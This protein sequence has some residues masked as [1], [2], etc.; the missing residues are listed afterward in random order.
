MGVVPMV[1]IL[2]FLRNISLKYKMFT[3]VV[4]NVITIT[5]SAFAA[6]C[7]CTRSYNDLIFQALAG[8]LS[9]SAC[10]IAEKLKNIEDL[11]STILS[12]PLIQQHLS[13]LAESEDTLYASEARRQL[14]AALFSLSTPYDSIG[15][16]YIALYNPQFTS[17]TNWNLLNSI[18]QDLLSIALSQAAEQEGAVTWIP[19]RQK[20]NLI[21]GRSIRKVENLDLTPIGNLLI[22]VDLE[23]LVASIH[24]TSSLW[25]DTAYILTDHKNRRIYASSQFRFQDLGP[26]LPEADTPYQLVSLGGHTYFLVSGTLPGY[27]YR[28][29]NLFPYDSIDS[30][31]QMTLGATLVIMI[32]GIV[33]I[34]IVS[35]KLIQLVARQLDDLIFKMQA[36]SQD[37]LTL[38]AG[39]YDYLKQNDEIGQ[40]HQQF[41][42][43]A[44]R[45][46]TLVKTNY[47]N[48]LLTTEMKLKTL[49][50]QINPHFL[51]N[52]LES[53]NWRAKAMQN[54]EISQMAESLGMILRMTL[55]T[56]KSLVTLAYELNLVRA[57]MT[58]QKIR[59][60]ERLLYEV[61][62]GESIGDALIPPLTIQPLVE[63]AI[64]YGL[65]EMIENCHIII[66]AIL[67]NMRLIIRVK[68]EGSCFEPNL[69]ETLKS[70]QNTPNG[71][72]IGLMNVQ[73]R[74]RIL[75]GEEYG[76]SF[77]NEGSYAVATLTLPYQKEDK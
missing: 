57:Y 14:N 27:D 2:F 33:F 75:F 48:Q 44:K 4:F 35:N 10:S 52:T 38:P 53:I 28:Y 54:T 3:L 67:V 6:Y 41:D 59:F 73:Q 39:T 64:R 25:E 8:N 20:H 55:A 66:E 51:Y 24:Q 7:Y 36:F 15:L 17:C 76:L 49:E 34:L 23:Q 5:L 21:L 68:N 50:S 32:L 71:F 56:K 40:L 18:D 61:N 13:H 74:T 58:I 72:G 47:A 12:S 62:V 70:G 65:E 9:V 1:K 77:S 42:T 37:E 69:L 31:I 19:D 30:S 29:M 60:E 16:A 26:S 45:I 63:N 46:Q 22:G 11:S 43:M